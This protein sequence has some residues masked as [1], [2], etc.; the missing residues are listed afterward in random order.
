[1]FIAAKVVKESNVDKV[2]YS[3]HDARTAAM[4][5]FLKFLDKARLK[6]KPWEENSHRP[7]LIMINY[8]C[9]VCRGDFR[10]KSWYLFTKSVQFLLKR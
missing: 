1:M 7:G 6:I 5:N 2:K 9:R 3:I 10:A 8:P 4:T